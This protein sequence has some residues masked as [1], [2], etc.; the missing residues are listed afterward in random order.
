MMK[1]ATVTAKYAA[2]LLVLLVRLVLLVLAVIAV[3]AVLAV[4]LLLPL[5]GSSDTEPV[6][7]V[8]GCSTRHMSCN[9]LL[10]DCSAK[11]LP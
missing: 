1:Y 7:H 5:L 6:W 2:I 10:E 9:R 11:A 4:V 3:L 8:V